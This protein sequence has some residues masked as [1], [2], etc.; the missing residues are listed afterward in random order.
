MDR[1]CSYQHKIEPNPTWGPVFWLCLV[2]RGALLFDSYG[3]RDVLGHSTMR[4]VL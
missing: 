4:V 1:R 3:L 2:W